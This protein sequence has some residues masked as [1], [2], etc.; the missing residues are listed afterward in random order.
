MKDGRAPGRD[1]MYNN[2]ITKSKHRTNSINL[3]ETVRYD[4]GTGR[5]NEGMEGGSNNKNT[6]KKGDLTKRDNWRAITLLPTV[7]KVPNSKNTARKNQTRDRE[8][9]EEKSSRIPSKMLHDRP[10]IMHIMWRILILYDKMIL[11]QLQNEGRAWRKVH[12]PD[13]H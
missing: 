9:A 2:R 4:M 6:K 8:K 11:Q 12:R 1:N 5:N 10:H 3:T 13:K 7:P